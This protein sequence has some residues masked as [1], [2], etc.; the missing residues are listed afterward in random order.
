MKNGKWG[1]VWDAEFAQ[2]SDVRVWV[3]ELS[4][5]EVTF[6]KGVTRTKACVRVT[7]TRT[8]VRERQALA[9]ACHL[10]PRG[11]P[12]TNIVN[13]PPPLSLS[14]VRPLRCATS[15]L[16]ARPEEAP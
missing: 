1:P 8:C 5:A 10:A 11:T 3:N 14:S 4:L 16:W 7:S 6:V 2:M 12:L 9:Q 15:P 13:L